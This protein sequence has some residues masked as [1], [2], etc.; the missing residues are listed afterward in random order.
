MYWKNGCQM[1]LNNRPMINMNGQMDKIH[2][3]NMK[4]VR[5]DNRN[6]L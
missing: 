5:D 2:Y 3:L 1:S 4:G 6:V